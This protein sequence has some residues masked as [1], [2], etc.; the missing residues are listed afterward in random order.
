MIK[1]K[2]LIIAVSVMFVS[3]AIA[4]YK[5]ATYLCHT[6]QSGTE[7]LICTMW[8][9]NRQGELVQILVVHPNQPWSESDGNRGVNC[10]SGDK[11]DSCTGDTIPNGCSYTVTRMTC[12]GLSGTPVPI[13][14][15]VP[16]PIN[17]TI[18]GDPCGA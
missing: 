10:D 7:T 8:E 18:T 11:Y 6:A 12:D 4:C 13:T 17:T 9:F 16:G 14:Y 1:S 5:N 3:V 2:M 15:P